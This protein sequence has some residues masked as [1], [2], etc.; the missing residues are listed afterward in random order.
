MR[1]GVFVLNDDSLSFLRKSFD[2]EDLR[3][4]GQE[5]IKIDSGSS[6]STVSSSLS[7]LGVEDLSSLPKGP[8]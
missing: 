1:R 4:E 8:E 5:S 6:S 2:S 3:A 7:D